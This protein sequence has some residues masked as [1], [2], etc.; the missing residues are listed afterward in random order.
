MDDDNFVFPFL[1]NRVAVV[2]DDNYL[3]SIQQRFFPN[4]KL[5]SISTALIILNI[6][7]FVVIHVAFP[8]GNYDYFLSWPPAMDKW[9][10]D[11]DLIRGNRLYMYQAVTALFMHA[12]Y[13]HLLGNMVF[14]LWVM[15]EMENS[16]R[17][18]IP[19]GLICGFAANCL[20]VLT[21]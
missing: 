10:L 2:N 17:W 16:W 9:L 8:P 1:S 4:I 19:M 13:L 21:L 3:K 14:A 11:I 6:V 18:S 15:Y 5:L 20:A 7:I 12:Y